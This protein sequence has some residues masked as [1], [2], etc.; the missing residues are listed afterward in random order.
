MGEKINGVL[1]GTLYIIVFLVVALGFFAF[2]SN[3]KQTNKLKRYLDY[4]KKALAVGVL[5]CTLHAFRSFSRKEESHEMEYLSER[6]IGEL[7]QL[8]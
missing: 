1:M 4:K 6:P 8:V 5:P 3:W 2:Q 7:I